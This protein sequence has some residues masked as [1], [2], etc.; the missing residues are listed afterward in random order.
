MSS[1]VPPPHPAHH[2]PLLHAPTH[3]CPQVSDRA[4]VYSLGLILWELCMRQRPWVGTRSAVIGYRVAMER[5]RPPLPPDDCPLCP[6]GLRSL[7]TRCGSRE[8]VWACAG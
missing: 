6:P 1:L 3:T 5:Q 4:D 7:I 8:C 2:P